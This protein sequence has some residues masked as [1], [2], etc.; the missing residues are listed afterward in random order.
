[1]AGFG[2]EDP[3]SAYFVIFL[4]DNDI[5]TILNAVLGRSYSARPSANDTYSIS[6]LTIMTQ[7]GRTG[8]MRCLWKISGLLS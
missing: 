1:M 6:H 2:V 8:A 7:Q 4:K 5:K 3:I